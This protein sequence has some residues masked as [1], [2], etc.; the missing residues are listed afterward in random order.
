MR[1]AGCEVDRFGESGDSGSQ[2]SLGVVPELG[3][4][5]V[6]IERALHHGAL[7]S[8]PTAMNQPDF[9]ESSRM[10]RAQILLNHVHD[11]PRGEGMQVE[12]ILNR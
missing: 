4:E 2:A 9:A 5:R 8:P 11:I 1:G 3:D 12:R 10:R 7:H 6:L